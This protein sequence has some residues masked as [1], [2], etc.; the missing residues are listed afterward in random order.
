MPPQQF[1]RLLDVFDQG[2]DLASH[3]SFAPFG[4]MMSFRL[5]VF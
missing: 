5:I 3:D 2:F 1:Q 4:G